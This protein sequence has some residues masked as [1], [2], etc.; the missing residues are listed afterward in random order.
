MPL[1][2]WRPLTEKFTQRFNKKQER[3]AK[4]VGL[5]LVLNII[6]WISVLYA[7]GPLNLFSQVAGITVGYLAGI[8]IGMYVFSQTKGVK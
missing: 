7:G 1:I 8:L 4:L 2:N 6:V 3:I 5:V